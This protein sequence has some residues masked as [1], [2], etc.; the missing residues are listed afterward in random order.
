MQKC[1][2]SQHKKNYFKYIS[3]AV[4][5]APLTADLDKEFRAAKGP[6]LQL[7]APGLAV[8]FAQHK[9]EGIGPPIVGFVHLAGLG[10][11]L[12]PKR[13]RP[14]LR[15]LNLGAGQHPGVVGRL[16]FEESAK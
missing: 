3:V 5:A 14:L 4:F 6:I 2:H 13:G 8:R 12:G 7:I 10:K 15:D 16:G 11:D 1:G 9:P